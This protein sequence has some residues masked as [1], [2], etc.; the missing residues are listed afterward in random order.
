VTVDTFGVKDNRQRTAVLSLENINVSNKINGV[1]PIIT[2]DRECLRCEKIFISQSISNRIC[3]R[4]KHLRG[5]R[6]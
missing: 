1:M 3:N 4:C 2:D 6:F 5:D